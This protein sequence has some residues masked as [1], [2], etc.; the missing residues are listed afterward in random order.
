MQK[1]AGI[2]YS[3]SDSF[4][5][6]LA[7]VSKGFLT[8]EQYDEVFSQFES[9]AGKFAFSNSSESN[10]IRILSSFFDKKT[11][12]LDSLKFEHHI[13]I[14]CA[15]SSYSN[16]LTDIVV[17]NPEYM[18]L[19]FDQQFLTSNV[20]EEELQKEVTN[21]IGKFKSLSAKSKMI[22]NIKRKYLLKIGVS[23]ILGFSDLNK[24]T[25]ELSILAKILSAALFEVCYQEVQ[26]KYLVKLESSFVLC[27]LGKLGGNELNYSS[28][29]DLILFYEK[30]YEIP[31]IKKEYHELITEATQLFIKEAST[32]TPESY[33]FRVDFRLRP[34]GR[35]SLLCRTETDYIRYYETRGEEW[36][37]QML[38]KLN[39]VCGN[40]ELYDH[41]KNYLD[42][43]IYPKTLRSSVIETI[44]KMKSSIE[45]RLKDDN[46]IKLTPGGIRD[47]EFAVQALQLI[48]AG[49]KPILKTGNTLI[50]LIELHKEN[51]LSE[52]E[53]EQLYAAY[54]FFR[55]I[56]HFVQLMN[57]KQ[58]H[59]LPNS[60]ELSEKLALYLDYNSNQQLTKELQISK[61]QVRKIYKNITSLDENFTKSEFANIKFKDIKK[62]TGN[63]DFLR[64]GLSLLG[65][66]QFDRHTSKLFKEIEPLIISY[67][68]DNISPD[69]IIENF[70]RVLKS[71]KLPSVW[72]SAFNDELFLNSF[73]KVC[74]LSQRAIDLMV[75]SPKLADLFL[76]KR[77]FQ[78]IEN[79]KN[80]YSINE[81]LFIL[82][83]QHACGIIE[84]P[85]FSRIL[86]DKI[87]DIISSTIA[88]YNLSYNFFV[89]GLGSFGNGEISFGSDIDLIV[90]TE[91]V[92][93][94]LQAEKDFQKILVVL[95]NRLSPFEV[96]FRLRPEGKNSPLVSDISGF[97]KY[98]NSR[99]R[100]WEFQALSKLKL[101]FGSEYLKNKLLQYVSSKL[102]EFSISEIDR[103]I[104]EMY[105]SKLSLSISN[106]KK[107]SLKS[108]PGGLLTVDTIVSLFVMHDVKLFE[109]S[110]GVN[111]ID[112][113][114]LIPFAELSWLKN[115]ICYLKN[116]QIALQNLQNQ[117]KSAIP[118]NEE[119]INLLA[120]YL[121]HKKSDDFTSKLDKVFKENINLLKKYFG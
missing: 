101:L 55:K 3:M 67:L 47:I 76:S 79:N 117:S 56:E 46:N 81:L 26:N 72:Y 51:L 16:Y 105:K 114:E 33:L 54:K 70:V 106:Q 6:F 23:D 50:A 20:L 75:T 108:S 8:S 37:R 84:F 60:E 87:R 85:Y 36:E 61:E 80:N 9:A 58:T 10:L 57:D 29:I 43:F 35:N 71:V 93:D 31:D 113:I 48:N 73:L 111:S 17:R 102:K 109:K 121:G 22:R 30:N 12:L 40:H 45:A 96:D 91:N 7:E 11:F 115:N 95:K 103:Q 15:I 44:R 110:F 99:M 62:A 86:C 119:K 2:K 65:E 66:R 24:V 68:S 69:L 59:S 25:S 5:K 90:V 4:E 120:I 98:I 82:S 88:E 38:I 97:E 42:G 21:S 14:I 92:N 49:K 64:Y 32:V 1:R 78:R 107:L 112:K 100:I 74:H 34:D 39:F 83:V 41:F 77:V 118:T 104:L 89:G 53:F 18:Y 94:N 52:E 28:D 63:F 27:S 116:V 13:E 19:L